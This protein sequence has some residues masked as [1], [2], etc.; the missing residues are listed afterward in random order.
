MHKEFFHELDEKNYVCIRAKNIVVSG[1]TKLLRKIPILRR[2]SL[3][4]ETVVISKL[5]IKMHTFSVLYGP[6]SGIVIYS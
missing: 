6:D 1:V 3:Y 5:A 2:G 4:C